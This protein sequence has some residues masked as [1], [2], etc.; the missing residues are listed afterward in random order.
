[1]WLAIVGL[2]VIGLPLLL[3]AAVVMLIR[4]RLAGRS[5]PTPTAGP[6]ATGGVAA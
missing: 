3:V 5:L 2:P 1:M 6:D 4:R